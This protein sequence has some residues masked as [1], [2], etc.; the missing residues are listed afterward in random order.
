MM[1]IFL[2]KFSFSGKAFL[3][4]KK[5]GIIIGEKRKMKNTLQQKHRHSKL[6]FIFLLVAGFTK[7]QEIKPGA[8]KHVSWRTYFEPSKEKLDE[9]FI[10]FEAVVDSGFQMF[11][12][13]QMPGLPV[14]MDIAI[15]DSKDFDLK[16]ELISPKPQIAFSHTYNKPVAVYKGKVAFRQKIKLR[17][18]NEFK[19]N[20][21]VENEEL[22][23]TEEIAWFKEEVVVSVRPPKGIRLRFL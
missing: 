15:K 7:A 16:G 1:Q 11:A 5:L 22:S 23:K 14:G 18:K 3:H 20:A 17:S 19:L 10:V 13:S 21:T 9:G 8:T 4:F 2:E 6:F 12:E